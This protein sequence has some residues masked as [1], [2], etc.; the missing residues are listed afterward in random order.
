[1]LYILCAPANSS[2]PLFLI[3]ITSPTQQQQ[4]QTLLTFCFPSRSLP[5]KVH[6]HQLQNRFPKYRSPL[7]LVKG[8]SVGAA[9]SSQAGMEP[10]DPLTHW[11]GK[12]NVS[13]TNFYIPQHREDTGVMCHKTRSF[14]SCTYSA[15]LHSPTPQSPRT[16]LM[17][18]MH[19]HYSSGKT[20][21]MPRVWL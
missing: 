7:T 10:W 11:P 15:T 17:D 16:E 9:P 3:L 6:M 21:C 14:L 13:G 12:L 4:P 18:S 2:V 20:C 8:S 19:S 5:F 1:M